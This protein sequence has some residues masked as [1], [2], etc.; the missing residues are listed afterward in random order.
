MHSTLRE[1]G[2]WGVTLKLS[3]FRPSRTLA[4]TLFAFQFAGRLTPNQSRHIQL[5]GFLPSRG[6]G[7]RS[8]TLSKP[9]GCDRCAPL[10]ANESGPVGNASRL[11]ALWKQIAARYRDRPKTLFFELFNEPQDKFT[12]QRWDEVFPELLQEIR[13]N[14]P[15][16]LVIVGPSYWNSLDHLPLLHLPQRRSSTDRDISLLQSV[17]FY[18]SSAELDAK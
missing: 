18:A 11:L 4:S 6:L 15:K 17:A 16:R 12:D 5:S 10:R 8:G 13:D 1:E 9:V 7:H 3:I 2:A 14:D